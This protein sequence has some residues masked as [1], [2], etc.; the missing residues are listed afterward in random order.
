MRRLAKQGWTMVVVT[1]EMRFARQV[2]DQV[3]FIDHGKIIE[4]GTPE[5]ILQNPKKARTKE[6]LRRIIGEFEI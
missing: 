4:H 2:A 6:F 5:Q 3:I 1:H